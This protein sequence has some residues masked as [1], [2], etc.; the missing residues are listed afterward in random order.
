MLTPSS[1]TDK[2]RAHAKNL[3]I[4]GHA[5]RKVKRASDQESL[6]RELGS[7]PARLERETARL[8][9]EQGLDD[10]GLQKS[11]NELSGKR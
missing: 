2:Q 5:Q 10:A 3:V 7:I 11:L 1:M 9:R 8:V 4:Q 6:K